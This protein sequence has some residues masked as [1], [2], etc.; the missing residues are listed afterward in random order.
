[1]IRKLVIA[2]LILGG[3]AAAIYAAGGPG[4]LERLIAH[5]SDKAKSAATEV[6]P[7]VVTVAKVAEA[8]FVETVLVTGSLVAREEIMIAPEVDGLRVIAISVDVGDRVKKGQVLATLETET[9]DAQMAQNAANVA[10]ASA[11]I[12]Q[13]K[14]AIKEAEARLVEARQQLDRA[15]P[16]V[17]DGYVTGSAFDTREAAVKTAQAQLQASKDGLKAAEAEKDQ[18]EAQGRELSWRR[19]RTDVK[20]PVDGIVTRRGARIGAISAGTTAGQGEPMFRLIENGEIEL[21]AEVP[22]R[23][24][25][26]IKTGQTAKVVL[27]DKSELAGTVRLVSPEVDVA[28][29]LGRVRILLGAD[30]RLKIGAF[31]RGTIETATSRGLAVPVSAVSSTI[32]RE[33]VQVVT[34]DTVSTRKVSTGLASGGLI[35]IRD[36][37]AATDTVVARAGTFLRDGDRIRPVEVTAEKSSPGKLSQV[38]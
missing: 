3:I 9:L 13:A 16:L 26:K 36:G 32:G 33:T 20:S 29:R 14:S 19:T 6:L 10:R 8:E 4:V 2:G 34:G 28:S 1:M 17:K 38:Q 37:L 15:K 35:E 5:K 24:L 25:G 11:S 30:E 27:A 7:P 22:E 18:V 31:A 21:D 12:A 23:E